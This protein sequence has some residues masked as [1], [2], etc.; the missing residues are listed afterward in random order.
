MCLNGHLFDST[1][2]YAIFTLE[3][4]NIWVSLYDMLNCTPSIHIPLSMPTQNKRMSLYMKQKCWSLLTAANGIAALAPFCM[5]VSAVPALLCMDHKV[6]TDK[7]LTQAL[8]MWAAERIK[9]LNI[10]AIVMNIRFYR[11]ISLNQ[12][13]YCHN[14]YYSYY[15]R[16]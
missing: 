10:T 7:P 3:L 4:A 15:S 16:Y 6:E 8:L 9:I 14:Y 1:E 11:Y 5:H 12:H 13:Y 2:S